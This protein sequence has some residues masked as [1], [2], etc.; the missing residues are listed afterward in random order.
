MFWVSEKETHS[1]GRASGRS[2]Y[3]EI[4]RLQEGLAN[5]WRVTS[6]LVPDAVAGVVEFHALG[7]LERS[8]GDV[9]LVAVETVEPVG[10]LAVGQ[11]GEGVLKDK[12]GKSVVRVSRGPSSLWGRRH[13]PWIPVLA[14]WRWRWGP[15]TRRAAAGGGR[16][17]ASAPGRCSRP[18]RGDPVPSRGQRGPP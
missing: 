3:Q 4:V 14:G 17:R 12:Q 16:A 18:G 6:G 5:A 11:E 13:L 9:N 1:P 10:S 2:G 8:A 15:P 7:F